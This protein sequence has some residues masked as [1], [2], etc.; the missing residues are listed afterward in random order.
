MNGN[1]N[2]NMPSFMLRKFSLFFY[3][4]IQKPAPVHQH[5]QSSFS[6]FGLFLFTL[7][8]GY[9]SLYVFVQQDLHN[10]IGLPDVVLDH[11]AMVSSLIEDSKQ[12]LEKNV[13]DSREFNVA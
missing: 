3:F 7:I 13:Y 11:F 12:F 2:E 6:F 8:L 1:G 9:I 4:V 5:P 10:D